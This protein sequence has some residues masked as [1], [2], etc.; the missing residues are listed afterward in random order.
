LSV[1]VSKLDQ[2]GEEPIE[3]TYNIVDGVIVMRTEDPTVISICSGVAK[4]AKRYEGRHFVGYNGDINWDN[5]EDVEV[6]G[7]WSMG[8][9]GGSGFKLVFKREEDEIEQKMSPAEPIEET[10]L[11]ENPSKDLDRK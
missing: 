8:G 1:L 10:Q 4:I 11:I 3:G 7:I 5:K 6:N 9:G 2:G